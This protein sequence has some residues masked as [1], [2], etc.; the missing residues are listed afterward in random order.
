MRNRTLCMGVHRRLCGQEQMLQ[1]SRLPGTHRTGTGI[2]FTMYS[3]TASMLYLSCAEMGTTGAP[4]AMVPCSAPQKPLAGRLHAPPLQVGCCQC[5]RRAVAGLVCSCAADNLRREPS[6]R[7]PTQA[8]CRLGPPHLDERLD[9]VVLRGGLGLIYEVD[10][11]LQDDDVLQLHDLHGRQVL[12]R[13]QETSK[14]LRTT[15]LGQVTFNNP[16]SCRSTSSAGSQGL[17]AHPQ[18]G[19]PCLQPV[20]TTSASFP[21]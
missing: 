18:T 5:V 9:L 4:S 11:V 12:C 20:E 8:G 19:T 6:V 1:S 10:L 15:C 16:P 2:F 3:H 14:T 7:G 17:S 21:Y 13:G